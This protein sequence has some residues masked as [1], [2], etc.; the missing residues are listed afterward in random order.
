MRRVTCDHWEFD[1]PESEQ[2]LELAIAATS[3]RWPDLATLLASCGAS[4]SDG[5]PATTG[6]VRW[7][8]VAAHLERFGGVALPHPTQLRAAVLLCDDWNDVELGV[9]F[10]STLLWYHWSTSA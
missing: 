5:K 8:E 7:A 6:W 10:G 4:A 1:P 9:E 2:A 3:R